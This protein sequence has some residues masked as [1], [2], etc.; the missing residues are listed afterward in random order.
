MGGKCWCVGASSLWVM[1]LP[2]GHGQGIYHWAIEPVSSEDSL[3]CRSILL[4][5]GMWLPW[6]F[7]R[8]KAYRA[9]SKIDRSNH[10]S[11]DQ[12]RNVNVE[13][14]HQLAGTDRKD[15]DAGF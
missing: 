11:V 6:L 7:L 1:L 10:E 14:I 8:R 5:Q 9:K 13:T 2:P 12:T 15:R 4:V 3:V